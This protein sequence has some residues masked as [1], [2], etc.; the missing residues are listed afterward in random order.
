MSKTRVIT[1]K[2]RLSYVHVFEPTSMEEGQ[3][4]KY[5]T[6][7]IIPKSNKA[8]VK[9][10]E[11]AITAAGEEGK[12]KFNNKVPKNLKSPLRDGDIDREDDPT[13][14]DAYFLNAKSTRRPGV[15]DKALNPIIDPEELYSGCYARVS[16]GFYAFNVSGNKGIACALNNIQKLADGERLAGG[17]S[18][19]DDFS[20]FA[21]DD[22]DLI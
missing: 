21:E 2:V 5:S 1:D 11:A 13:Y 6:N 18:A 14:E 4:P 3:T 8:L 16:I 15:V 19:E 17:P 10:I 9:K 12:A 22:D 20:D 7:I